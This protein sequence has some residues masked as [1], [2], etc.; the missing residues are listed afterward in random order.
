MSDLNTKAGLLLAASKLL[1]EGD[2]E[3]L[4]IEWIH[5][6]RGRIKAACQELGVEP[7]PEGPDL[8][9]RLKVIVVPKLTESTQ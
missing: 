7:P 8:F 4:F 9:D 2:P 1:P 6:N 3:R 5:A